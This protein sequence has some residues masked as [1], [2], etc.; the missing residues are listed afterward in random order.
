MKTLEQ[1]REYWEA[2][3]CGTGYADAPKFTAQFY[4][5]VEDKRYQLEPFIKEFAQ[6]S[7]WRGKKVLEVGVGAGT[8]FTQF[9]RVGALSHG[10]D[11]TKEA[12]RH[13]TTRLA[14]EGLKASDLRQ[15]NAEELPYPSNSFDLVYSWG[16][17]HHSEDP[18]KAFEQ[19]YR[20]AKPGGAIKVMV[21][22]LNS[23]IT[24]LKWVRH[25]LLK[26]RPDRDRRWALWNH[27]ESLGT[28]AYT[29]GI[30]RQWV[31][32]LPHSGLRFHYYAGLGQVLRYKTHSTVLPRILDVLEPRRFGFFLAF[33][34]IKP[35]PS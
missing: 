27:M 30:I 2:E 32:G 10:V 13:V 12:I 35:S 20:V 25:A 21:Y 17:I 16:V 26:G 14:Y 33:E 15:A 1:V 4:K 5:E 7:S 31:K 9:V 18:Q 29:E 6:F 24:W 28:K 8:D 3:S 22:N 34:F 19:I 23:S 11:L